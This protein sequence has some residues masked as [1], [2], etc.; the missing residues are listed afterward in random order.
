MPRSLLDKLNQY[1]FILSEIFFCCYLLTSFSIERTVI[2]LYSHD[3][4]ELM[5]PSW[6]VL[7][8]Y[9]YLHNIFSSQSYNN[10]LFV[11]EMYFLTIIIVGTY[12]SLCDWR[13]FPTFVVVTL[14][15]QSGTLNVTSNCTYV[16]VTK[17]P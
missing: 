16:F 9:K 15:S 5:A 13:L 8:P 7:T 17:S 14:Y 6:L 1:I 12:T 11:E 10:A 4:W 2:Y 3:I